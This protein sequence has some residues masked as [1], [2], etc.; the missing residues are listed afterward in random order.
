MEV[1]EN[2]LSF[3]VIIIG[4]YPN[5]AAGLGRYVIDQKH[6]HNNHTTKS[7]RDSNEKIE[8]KQTDFELS[9]TEG[10][11]GF[12][13]VSGHRVPVS[14]PRQ[15]QKQ[16]F[17]ATNVRTETILVMSVLGGA[18][19]CL[20]LMQVW[21]QIRAFKKRRLR[22]NNNQIIEQ[23]KQQSGNSSWNRDQIQIVS[24][25]L[26]SNACGDLQ[27]C[28]CDAKAMGHHHQHGYEKVTCM[29]TSLSEEAASDDALL[30]MV[31]QNFSHHHPRPEVVHVNMNIVQVVHHCGEPDPSKC[32][33]D[34]C[35]KSLKMDTR[36]K[37]S[38]Q[39][40]LTPNKN[41]VSSVLPIHCKEGYQNAIIDM[42]ELKKMD[43][44]WADGNKQTKLDTTRLSPSTISRKSCSGQSLI[45]NCESTDSDRYDT[46]VNLQDMKHSDTAALLVKDGKRK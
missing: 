5:L 35:G 11:N 32:K 14:G 2:I 20:I 6:K 19:M 18:L 1:S 24:A 13:S 40:S 17:D 29:T 7:S 28:D 23:I 42:D 44:I 31:Q 45:S 26:V 12:T 30:D 43:I 41:C 21:R 3:S 10:Y 9:N 36:K 4:L 27:D 16:Q 37:S 8:S 33:Q 46:V 39:S 38:N 25:E 15:M 34:G 22:N